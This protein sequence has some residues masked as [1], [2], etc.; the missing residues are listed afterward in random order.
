M[1]LWHCPT[2]GARICSSEKDTLTPAG[3]ILRVG[4]APGC[5]LLWVLL[6]CPVERCRAVLYLHLDTATKAEYP[7][8]V[9]TIFA[10]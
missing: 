4:M 8:N 6:R 1:I 5:R 3:R 10:L 7:V 9:D 2:C